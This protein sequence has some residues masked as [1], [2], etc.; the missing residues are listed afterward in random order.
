MTENQVWLISTRHIFTESPV[1][2]LYWILPHTKYLGGSAVVE[3][4][5]IKSTDCGSNF[6][7]RAKF[8]G[9]QLRTVTGIFTEVK[10]HYITATVT[11]DRV[12][13]RFR[14][15]LTAFILTLEWGETRQERS[16]DTP[17]WEGQ[18]N[19]ENAGK[20]ENIEQKTRTLLA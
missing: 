6:Q 20:Q 5:P 10:I 8:C 7:L 16:L 1:A 11:F 3:F 2:V 4:N 17:P 15:S 14:F 12:E 19:K 9:I 18:D 13:F